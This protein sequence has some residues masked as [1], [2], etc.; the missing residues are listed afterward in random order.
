MSNQVFKK[1]SHKIIDEVK[2]FGNSVKML[3]DNEKVLGD[4]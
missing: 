4:S 3:G 1:N 2:M